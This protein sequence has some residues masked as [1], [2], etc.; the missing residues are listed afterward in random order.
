MLRRTYRKEAATFVRQWNVLKT[1]SSE[2]RSSVQ[3]HRRQPVR[4]KTNGPKEKVKTRQLLASLSASA[5]GF[6]CSLDN[7]F[8]TFISDQFRESIEQRNGCIGVAK[9]PYWN[10]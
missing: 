8:K 1:G 7:S 2:R 4:M 6:S 9:Q 3:P 10:G 5:F